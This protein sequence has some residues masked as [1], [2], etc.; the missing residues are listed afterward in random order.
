MNDFGGYLKKERI[1]RNI[2]LEEI[3]KST[4]ISVRFLSALEANRLEEIGAPV[5]IKGFIKS[6]AKYLNLDI[7]EVLFAYESYIK[8]TTPFLKEENNKKSKKGNN[9]IL[10]L[11][12]TFLLILIVG[13]HLIFQPEYL[14]SLELTKWFHYIFYNYDYEKKTSN[15]LFDPQ[16]FI[17]DEQPASMRLIA[18]AYEDMII[19][20]QVDDCNLMP[21]SLS[22]GE[23]FRIEASK[24]FYVKLDYGDA[25]QFMYNYIPLDLIH[26]SKGELIEFTLPKMLSKLSTD[27]RKETEQIAFKEEKE[28]W[29]NR[30][31]R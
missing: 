27:P 20:I 30:L 31:I 19:Y 23:I 9:K 7:N 25:V 21:I 13:L 28:K 10:F 26:G 11:F 2:S 18:I 1:S 22:K 5:H 15:L 29:L 6:Y 17:C 12:F 4:K 14:K 3:S 8:N 16:G 24:S